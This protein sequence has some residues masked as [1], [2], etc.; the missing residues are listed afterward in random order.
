MLVVC[1]KCHKF[2]P[3]GLFVSVNFIGVLS[4]SKKLFTHMK[5]G[6]TEYLQEGNHA[7]I[8]GHL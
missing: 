4:H 7:I 6:R 5:V 2:I 8:L 3:H 1:L